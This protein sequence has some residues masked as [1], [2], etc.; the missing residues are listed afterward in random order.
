MCAAVARLAGGGLGAVAAPGLR[1]RRE[2]EM[3]AV[4][5]TAVRYQMYHAFALL[6]A[7]WGWARWRR[8]EFTLAGVL[9]IGG[10]VMFS[11][12]LYGLA[13]SGP[14]WLGP[15][16]PL[17]GLAFLGGWLCLAWGALRARSD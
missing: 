4:F 16:T 2:P 6:A 7:A 3:L 1:A 10:I 5:E 15:V 17:G 11:G 12:S 13:L 8:R 14:R 9:F